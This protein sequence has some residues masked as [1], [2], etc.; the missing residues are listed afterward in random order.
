MTTPYKELVQKKIREMFPELIKD[1]RYLGPGEGKYNKISGFHYLRAL[2]YK[3]FYAVNIGGLLSLWQDE[4]AWKNGNQ[5]KRIVDFSIVTGEP[6]TSEDWK[7][8]S[9]ILQI[10]KSKITSI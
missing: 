3:E 2:P 4:K 10:N 5:A 8:L 7:K 1:E 6:V 9:E